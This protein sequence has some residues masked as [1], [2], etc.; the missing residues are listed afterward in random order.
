MSKAADMA[1]VSAKGSFHLLWGLVISTV[2]SSVATIFI[3]AKLGS[4]L[5]GLYGIVQITPNLIAIF[6]DWGINSA[7]IRFT[8]Q[9]RAED[10]ATEI[11][12]VLLTGILFELILGTALSLVSFVFA[13]YVATTFFQRPEITTLIQIASLSILAGGLVNA[14]AAAFTGLEKMELN[15]IML[16]CQSVIK[17]AIMIALVIIGL[18]TSGAV[19]G[20]TAAML[21]AGVIGISLTWTQYRKLPKP[22]TAKLEIKAYTTS[23]LTYG[24]PLSLAGIVNGFQGQYYAFLLP[25]FYVIDNTAIGNYGIASTFVVLISFF[26]TPITTMLFPAFS[27]LDPQKD[28][29]ALLSVFQFSVRYAS[30]FVIPV[31]ALVMSLAEPAISTL[32][33]NAYPTAPL[34][35]ALLALAYVFPAF[36]SLSVSNFF[37]SQGRTKLNFYLTLTGAAVGFPLGYV[38]IM[39]I[40]VIGLI[41]TSIVAGIPGTII[42]LYWAKK[43]FGLT[44]DW[45]SSAKIL[46]SSGIAAGATYLFVST[47]TFSSPIRLAIGVAFYIVV[48]IAAALLTRTINKNDLNNLRGMTGGLRHRRQNPQPHTKHTRKNN[49]DTQTVRATRSHNFANRPWRTPTD[50]KTNLP[51]SH[52]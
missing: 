17:S 26:A 14:A 38:L 1:K 39:Q 30:L 23:M 37:N 49:D 7:M 32:F 21:I 50:P 25:I 45:A 4:D 18:S 40:G 10:R 48:F 33:Q 29:E 11:R 9:Y 41:V 35:L 51:N 16:I 13:G 2:I 19:I 6:R 8:A 42:A 47:L 34:F 36:G 3:A 5:Y 52:N 24:T 22:P 43:Y 44:V 27:K 12:S 46:L 31:A 20:Y 15:S 28:K